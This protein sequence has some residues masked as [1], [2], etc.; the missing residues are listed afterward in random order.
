MANYAVG[1]DDLKIEILSDYAT[2]L[3]GLYAGRSTSNC[4]FPTVM[5]KSHEECVSAYDAYLKGR[6]VVSLAGPLSGGAVGYGIFKLM[7]TKYPSAF[8]N[9]WFK[10]L[11]LANILWQDALNLVPG[12]YHETDG[13]HVYEY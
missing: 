1:A 10:G 2:L 5:D 12:I 9:R 3:T 6:I 7:Q 11:F 8:K 4:N 13:Q